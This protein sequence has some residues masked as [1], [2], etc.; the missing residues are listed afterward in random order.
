MSAGPGSV[1]D[2][3]AEKKIRTECAQVGIRA[4]VFVLMG[5]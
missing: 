2:E 3:H 4:V 1:D 5:E